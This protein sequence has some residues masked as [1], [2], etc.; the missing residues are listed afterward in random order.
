VAA[1]AP[2]R[3]D[4]HLTEVEWLVP[5]S[6]LTC[7][8]LDR[9]G[10][11]PDLCDTAENMSGFQWLADVE[12]TRPIWCDED[13]AAFLHQLHLGWGLYKYPKSAI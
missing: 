5:N 9:S 6:Y 3:F 11:A 10:G 4:V 13:R 2:D 7:R 8:S 1:S 12:V